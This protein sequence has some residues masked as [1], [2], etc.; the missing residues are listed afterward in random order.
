MAGLKIAILGPKIA[1]KW[2]FS[3]L[4]FVR[5]TY[6]INYFSTYRVV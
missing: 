4:K 1:K 6:E 3:P 2:E 5:G